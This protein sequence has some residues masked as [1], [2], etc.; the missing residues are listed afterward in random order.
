MNLWARYLAAVW[1]TFA[2]HS[3]R[4][5]ISF[6]YLALKLWPKFVAPVRA[7]KFLA[8][9]FQRL[10][11][12]Q[13]AL[14]RDES[15]LVPSI[16]VPKEDKAVAGTAGGVNTKALTKLP[17]T[18]PLPYASQI[19]L[20]A[21]YLCSYIPARNDVIIFSKLFAKKRRRGAS[22]T[23]KGGGARKNKNSLAQRRR[24]DRK[25]LGPQAFVVERLLAVFWCVWEEA[26]HSRECKSSGERRKG[27]REFGGS[28]DILA[29]IAMLSS[30]RLLVSTGKEGL[31]GGSKYRVN[32][33][34]EVVRSLGRGVA[35]ELGEWLE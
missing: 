8:T 31:D 7:G 9:D 34:W 23:V 10:F 5:L 12:S 30:L 16:I 33:G 1:D 22:G 20:L 3:G 21:A 18:P 29:Q 13:R 6:C 35:V 26:T 32:V 19:L 14:F 25:L 11:I 17:A 15:I 4:D 2:S 24:I 28:A 27:L